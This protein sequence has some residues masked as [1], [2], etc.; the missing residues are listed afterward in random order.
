MKGYEIDETVCLSKKFC[1]KD[2][3]M[4]TIE[5]QKGLAGLRSSGIVGLSP[6]HYENAA[7]L[8]IEKMKKT[9]AIDEAIFSMSIGMGDIQSK[10]TFGGY[11]LDKFA[12][13]PIQWHDIVQGSRYWEIGLR[14]ISF[15]NEIEEWSYGFRRGI[16][17]SGTSYT[18]VPKV[19]YDRLLKHLEDTYAFD[20]MIVPAG[21]VCGCNDF[22][23]KH[24]PDLHF[25]IDDK[26]Y[27]LPRESYVDF[28][29]DEMTCQV[30][31]MTHASLPIW[32]LGLNFFE[33]YY[34]VF[35]QEKL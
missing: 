22:S 9:G 19:D 25:Q 30:N 1:S 32:I 27:V 28:N 35:D 14:K 11:N 10:I 18:L 24:F 15:S 29:S 17:D 20:F 13:G 21:A 16:V 12:E 34:T 3:R 4:M 26:D 6:N 31:L 33:N 23:Y 7:D 2:F 8:F 5:S